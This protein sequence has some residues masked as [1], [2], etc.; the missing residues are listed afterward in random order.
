MMNSLSY[1]I[2]NTYIKLLEISIDTDSWMIE[3]GSFYWFCTKLS[4]YENV[5]NVLK[6]WKVESYEAIISIGKLI[7]KKNGAKL[8]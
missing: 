8:N 2:W 4:V 3:R 6:P 1:R 7:R 5:L